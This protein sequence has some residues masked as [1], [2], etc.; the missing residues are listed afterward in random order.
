MRKILS[1][2]MLLMTLFL[3]VVLP[4]AS[5]GIEPEKNAEMLWSERE[6]P[7][8]AAEAIAAY[9]D[10][11]K[12]M[13]DDYKVLLRLSRLHY[14]VGQILETSNAK[15]ALEHY[16]RGMEYGKEASGAAPEKP[17]GYFFEAANLA[18]Q[19]NLKGT[20]SNL[21]GVSTVRKLNEKA[22]LL[23]PEYF[24]RG[25]DRFF[26]AFYTKLPGLLGGS[27]TKAIEFGKRAVEA[28]PNYAGNRYFLA[29][30]YVKDGKNDLARKEL[31]AAV[32]LPDDEFP[33]VVPEQ[34][35]EKKRAEALLKRIA[36][37]I[38]NAVSE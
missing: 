10:L 17:G 6:D 22:A 3:I 31:E 20:F 23:D 36:K 13:P 24:Y 18:R 16:G 2:S 15:E 28:F 7:G 32:V 19:N 29:E 38:P 33:D 34:R 11:L 21:F 27:T 26:C 37:Q 4:T 12:E 35:M 1:C 14:W 25:T 8:K 30:A 9:E 5:R